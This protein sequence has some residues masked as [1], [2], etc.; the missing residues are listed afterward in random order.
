M[1][2]APA[3]MRKLLRYAAELGALGVASV[4]LLI[5]AAMFH[6]GVVRP[7]EARNAALNEHLAR[8][9]PRAV[10]SG[11][12]ATLDKV[13]AVYQQLESAPDAT[14]WLA[15][16]HAIGAATGVQLRAASYRTHD[17]EGRI[18]RYEVALPV[19][20]SYRQI[21]QFLGRSLSEIPAMSVDQLALKRESREDNA[22]QG[23]LRLTLHMVKS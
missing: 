18:V 13:S 14:D 22:V 20:G 19:S 6:F 5:A 7:L 2:G 4:I 12:L 1:E 9:V 17:T 8:Q 23:E 10:A 3:M 21:R 15:K 16:L 11:P